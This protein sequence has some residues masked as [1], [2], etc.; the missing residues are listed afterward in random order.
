VQDDSDLA[1]VDRL[2]CAVEDYLRALD[3]WE[4]AFRKYARIA[5]Y[6]SRAGD[7]LAPELCEYAAR[8][9]EL[10]ELL[11][12][13][14]LLCHRHRLREPFSGLLRISPRFSTPES[15][16]AI[17]RNE[18]STVTMCL[19]DLKAQAAGGGTEEP[20]RGH[21]KPSLLRRLVDFFY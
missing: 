15:G 19:V 8:R 1:F 9:C 3:C 20:A 7:D 6:K 11:P 10:S 5:G 16:S 4:E 2:R 12:R 14:R 21:E 17:G 13:A 18:R